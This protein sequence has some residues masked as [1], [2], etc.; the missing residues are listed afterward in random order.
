MS[1]PPGVAP[2]R[3]APPEAPTSALDRIKRLLDWKIIAVAL[4]GIGAAW[5]TWSSA[6]VTKAELDDARAAG[7]AEHAAM[8]KET[9]ELDRRV[10]EDRVHLEWIRAQLT[11]IARTVGAR[12]VPPPAQP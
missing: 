8:R 1:S 4:I 12:T 5:S 9:Q 10:T 2:R 11:E 3:T 6:L 7:A